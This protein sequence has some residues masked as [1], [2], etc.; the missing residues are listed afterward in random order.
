MTLL[1]LDI[2]AKE[3]QKS[4]FSA[5]NTLSSKTTFRII[6]DVVLKQFE[7]QL[8]N[9]VQAGNIIRF[10]AEWYRPRYDVDRANPSLWEF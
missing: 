3:F 9:R 8:E 1:K 5:I 10:K 7:N 2:N 4:L 6:G